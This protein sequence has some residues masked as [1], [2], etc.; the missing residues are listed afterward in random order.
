MFFDNN[1]FLGRHNWS[2]LSKSTNFPIFFLKFSPILQCAKFQY[3]KWLSILPLGSSLQNLLV[4][5][6]VGTWHIIFRKRRIS[7]KSV[8]SYKNLSIPQNWHLTCFTQ[9]KLSMI[10]PSIWYNFSRREQVWSTG[11]E[12]CWFNQFLEVNYSLLLLLL[13]LLC[14]MGS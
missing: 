5:W 12:K 6:Q 8:N 14:H 3:K 1:I 4:V 11:P 7:S 9:K 2:I 10:R 13:L